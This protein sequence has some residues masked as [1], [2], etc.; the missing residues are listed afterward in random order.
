M[1]QSS[2]FYTSIVAAFAGG[3]IGAVVPFFGNWV[4]VL[5]ENA[6]GRPFCSWEMAP[7][8]VLFFTV[9]GGLVV[10]LLG[11]LSRRWSFGLGIGAVLHAILFAYIVAIIDVPETVEYWV[12]TVGTLSGGIAGAV[13]GSRKSFK[14]SPDSD[15]LMK[16]AGRITAKRS[17]P[18]ETHGILES[19]GIQ[20][21]FGTACLPSP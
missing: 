19:S 10:G 15:A 4:G 21:I 8:I 1:K 5:L 3:V 2:F 13:G 20:R 9:P 6:V 16:N 7:L 18:L 12:F 14:L 17:L 11:I